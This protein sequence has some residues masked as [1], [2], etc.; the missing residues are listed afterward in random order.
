MALEEHGTKKVHEHV[1]HEPSGKTFNDFAMQPIAPENR[2]EG[3][4]PERVARPFNPMISSGA[5]MCSAMI[6]VS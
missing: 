5:I 2:V 3:C 6:K 1:G 4:V